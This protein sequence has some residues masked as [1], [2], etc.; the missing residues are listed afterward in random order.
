MRDL[1]ILL[2][3]DYNQW[4]MVIAWLMMI[5]VVWYVAAKVCNQQHQEWS[6]SG[7]IRCD[8]DEMIDF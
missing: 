6:E 3:L 8:G 2:R 5:F 4:M 1:Q 7:K